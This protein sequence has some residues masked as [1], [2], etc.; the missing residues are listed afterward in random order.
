GGRRRSGCWLWSCGRVQSLTPAPTFF[1]Y[2][3][4]FRSVGIAGHV[5]PFGGESLGAGFAR[6]EAVHDAF[7]GLGGSVGEKGVDLLR[8]R[9]QTDRKSTRLNSS[10]VK[11][12]YAVFCS[13]KKN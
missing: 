9:R 13:K 5:E 3:T 11:T 8:A 4:L 7:I 12:S 6:E 1:P 10:H 2:T